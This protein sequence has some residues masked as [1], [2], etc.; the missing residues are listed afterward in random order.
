[1]PDGELLKFNAHEILFDR[2]HLVSPEI[3]HASLEQARRL[4]DQS[5]PIKMKFPPLTQHLRI[6]YAVNRRRPVHLAEAWSLMWLT[7]C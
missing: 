3:V 7:S 6:F 1:M 4:L 2:P 5:P